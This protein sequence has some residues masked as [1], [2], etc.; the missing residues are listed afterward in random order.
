VTLTAEPTLTTPP[1]RR[2]RDLRTFWRVALAIALPVG[3]LLV[4]LARA[5]MPYWTS[6]D[7][8][9]VVA[10]MAAAP[11]LS[12]T[13]LWLGAFL[14]P[15]MLISMLTLGYV[16][17]RGAPVLATIGTVLSFGAYSLWGATGNF[18]YTATVLLGAGYSVDDVT[19]LTGHLDST[20]LSMVVGTFWVLGHILGLVIL[21]IALHRARVLPLWAAIVMALSQPVHLLSAVILPSRWLDV[22]G[23]WGM[24][25]LTCTLVAIYVWR[26]RNQDWDLPPVR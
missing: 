14:T 3:P 5:V 13:L 19:T 21:A 12:T 26:T 17:R 9:T 8:A 24:T 16:A 25:T 2:S 10:K 6:D 4:T 11:E 15:C 23:G 7:P 22:V 20:T 1:V 18:D